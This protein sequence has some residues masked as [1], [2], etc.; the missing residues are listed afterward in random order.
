MENPG[1]P[2]RSPDTCCSIPNLII[3]YIIFCEKSTFAPIVKRT[4][5][6]DYS[7]NKE[8]EF[9]SM[10]GQNFKI[11]DKKMKKN[12]IFIIDVEPMQIL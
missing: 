6:N 5:K 3:I 7:S 9:C 4:G 12:G 8:M 10:A 2:G 1:C 11:I